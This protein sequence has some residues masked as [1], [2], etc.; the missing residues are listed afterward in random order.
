LGQAIQTTEATLMAHAGAVKVSRGDLKNVATPEGTD[1]WKP[2]PHS[3]L[4]D[5][6]ENTLKRNN[7]RIQK[8]EY[9]VQ[10]E[11]AKLFG[12]MTLNSEHGDYALALGIRTS[13]DKSFP[14]QMIAGARVFVCDNL[15]FSG[16]VVTLKRRHTSGLDIRNEVAGGITRAISQFISMEGAVAKM[17]AIDLTGKDS[18]AKAKMLDAA[19]KGVMPLRLIPEVHKNYFEPKHQEFEPRTAWSLHNAFTEAFKLLKPNVAMQSGVELGKLF[20]V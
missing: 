7:F 19:V 16:S 3:L 9:A 14:V 11:G 4:V 12:V 10:T 6:I 15:A 1:S 2:V 17:K 20:N 5:C 8:E 13:N 18:F